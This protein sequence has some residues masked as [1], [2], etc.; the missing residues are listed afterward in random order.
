[1]S[2]MTAAILPMWTKT[3]KI[4][5]SYSLYTTG[6]CQIMLFYKFQFTPLKRLK[7]RKFRKAKDIYLF[8]SSFNTCRRR[9]PNRQPILLGDAENLVQPYHDRVTRVV[10]SDR[11][12]K[13]VH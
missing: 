10:S 3:S 5:P 4:S 11:G 9:N 6:N 13:I 1:M 12:C 2:H 8:F 7:I